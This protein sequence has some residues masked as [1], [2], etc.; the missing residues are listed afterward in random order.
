M[1]TS[2]PKAKVKKPGAHAPQPGSGVGLVEAA[3]D[4]KTLLAA[5]QAE[6]RKNEVAPIQDDLPHFDLVPTS[7]SK[8]KSIHANPEYPDEYTYLR[9]YSSH[10]N[11]FQRWMLLLSRGVSGKVKLVHYNL[12]TLVSGGGFAT[13]GLDGTL[14]TMDYSSIVFLIMLAGVFALIF[15]VTLNVLNTGTTIETDSLERMCR[16]MNQ[17]LPFMLGTYLAL[18]LH[19]WWMLREALSQLFCAI[20]NVNMVVSCVLHPR[21]HTAVRTL[22][23]KW[24]FASVFLLVKSVRQQSRLMDMGIKGLLSGEEIELLEQVT[25]L[26]ARPQIL[27]GW[28]MRIVHESFKE[29]VGPMPYSIQNSKVAELVMMASDG[30]SAIDIHLRTQIPFVYVHV[31]TLLVDINN[32]IFVAKSAVIA[33]VAH[34]KNDW[35]RQASELLCVFLVPFLYRGLLSISYVLFD[36]F[37]EDVLDFPVGSYMDWNAQCCTAILGAQENFPGVPESVYAQGATKDAKSDVEVLSKEEHIANLKAKFKR[38]MINSYR[39]GKLESAVKKVQTQKAEAADLEK[40]KAALPP[41]SNAKS[42]A[43]IAEAIKQAEPIADELKRFGKEFRL[44]MIVLRQAVCELK[45]MVKK[46]GD[47][48]HD[49]VAKICDKLFALDAAVSGAEAPLLKA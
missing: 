27:W 2:S 29:A 30:L 45:T 20:V 13:A 21:R 1:P 47:R 40:K 46:D 32:A 10:V 41:I 37:G 4:E 6:A 42:A 18:V 38:I 43:A 31:L 5:N 14:V 9:H 22:V 17:V 26:Q 28:V 16:R 36:P 8:R 44:K 35:G 24:S 11:I 12:E 33:A 39:S 23:V 48:Q 15:V 34:H 25:E 7:K 19:R 3:V 49:E